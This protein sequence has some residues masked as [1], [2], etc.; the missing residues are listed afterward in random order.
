MVS[1]EQA[2]WWLTHKAVQLG[3]GGLVARVTDVPNLDAALAAGVNMTRGVT[4]GDRAHHL[5]VAQSIDLACVAGNARADQRVGRKRHGLHLS[6]SAHMEGVR[7]GGREEQTLIRT[8]QLL[9]NCVYK[10]QSSKL[11]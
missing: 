5:P 10:Q 3:H 7:S 2:P 9:F 1:G 4:D 6:V 11:E 8:I